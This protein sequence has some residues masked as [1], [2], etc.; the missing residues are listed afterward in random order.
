MRGVAPSVATYSRWMGAP[1]T[2]PAA[3]CTTAPSSNSA[4]FSAVKAPSAAMSDRSQVLLQP[5]R[6]RALAVAQRLR[7]ARCRQP[8]RQHV[9]R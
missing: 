1:I 3:I 5:H 2:A 6:R 4:V 7:Y 8:A 9:Y